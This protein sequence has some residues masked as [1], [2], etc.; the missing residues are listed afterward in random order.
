MPATV[1]SQRKR[2]VS[3]KRKSGR[4]RVSKADQRAEMMELILDTAED[5]F[6]KHG[7]YGEIGRAHV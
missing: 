2:P 3:A 1:K 4:K 5:L 7:L 6:S